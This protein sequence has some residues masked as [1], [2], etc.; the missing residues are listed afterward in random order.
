MPYREIREK[1][2]ILSLDKY[3]CGVGVNL[4]GADSAP[5]KQLSSEYSPTRS[6]EECEFS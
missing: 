1:S 6:R 5:S 4:D 3:P 2:V